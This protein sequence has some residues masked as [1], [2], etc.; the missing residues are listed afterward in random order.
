MQLSQHPEITELHGI[1]NSTLLFPFQTNTQTCLPS[2]PT[3][4]VFRFFFFPCSILLEEGYDL[5]CLDWPIK[6]TW[7]GHG[8]LAKEH[9]CF[10]EGNW[11]LDFLMLSQASL[12]QMY[13][14]WNR[15]YIFF[16]PKGITLTKFVF[17]LDFFLNSL[18]RGK[19]KTSLWSAQR[20]S[21]FGP[22][23]WELLT[24]R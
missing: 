9:A 8:V 19:K 4:C 14:C 18:V 20:S 23:V 2:V 11:L 17:P 1:I 22:K 24:K 3:W 16:S 13:L 7:A 15:L 5:T 10:H 12:F 6:Q 21:M